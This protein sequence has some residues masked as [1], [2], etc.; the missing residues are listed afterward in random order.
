[1]QIV[2]LCI[3]NLGLGLRLHTSLRGNPAVELV[4]TQIIVSVRLSV[5]FSCEDQKLSAQSLHALDGFRL[6]LRRLASWLA[7]VC[8]PFCT[9]SA[10]VSHRTLFTTLHRTWPRPLRS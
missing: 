1:M 10:Q 4:M 9:S 3:S 8:A 2:G 5:V 7:G 6:R